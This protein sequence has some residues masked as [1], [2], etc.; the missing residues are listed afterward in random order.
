MKAS[1][2]RARGVSGKMRLSIGPLRATDL[3]DNRTLGPRVAEMIRE[4]IFRGVL[5]P[6]QSLRQEDLAARLG[7]SRIPIREAL[8][9][10]EAEGFVGSNP[11]KGAF[12]APLTHEEARDMRDIR[13]CLESLALRFAVPKMTRD[14]IR[15]AVEILEARSAEEEPIRWIELTQS[16]FDTLYAPADR[17]RLLS[18]IL[19]LHAQGHRYLQPLLRSKRNREMFARNTSAIVEA[20]AR[21][22]AEGAVKAL[23]VH[24]LAA[25]EAV[26]RKLTI[27]TGGRK[28]GGKT[29][30]REAPGRLR[31]R[32]KSSARG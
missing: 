25:V 10:L 5:K 11:Y 2:V 6:G 14:N 4:A 30:S 9:Q 31:R 18:F 29:R 7:V 22:D 12:V 17:P 23:H 28:I 3:E 1:G 15:R 16:L 13:L 19:S 20:C 21:G 8:R 27:G 26:A 24:Y 32:T